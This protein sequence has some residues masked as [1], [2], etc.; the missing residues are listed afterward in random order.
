M[1]RCHSARLRRAGDIVTGSVGK[2]NPAEKLVD[3]PHLQIPVNQRAILPMKEH[4]THPGGG[5]EN[6]PTTY[7]CR[8]GVATP[9]FAQQPQGSGMS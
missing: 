8:I 7:L 1:P 4:Q 6:A 2:P 9:T 5:N 3:S